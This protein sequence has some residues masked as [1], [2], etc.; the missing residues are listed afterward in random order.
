MS[1]FINLL[2]VIYPVGSIYC[3]EN[4][5]SPATLFGGTW[6]QI[7][8]AIL[9]ATGGNGFAPA[10]SSGGSLKINNYHLPEHKHF[11]RAATSAEHIED[12]EDNY[13]GMWNTNAASGSQWKLASFGGSGATQWVYAAELT[14]IGKEHNKDFIPY[15]YSV[16]VWVRTS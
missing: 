15:H 1:I 10:G 7:K 4:S 16:N 8:G 12:V 3:S 14:G 6:S 5:I 9:S 2:E 11:V 13:L